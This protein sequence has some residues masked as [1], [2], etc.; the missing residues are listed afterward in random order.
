MRLPEIRAAQAELAAAYGIHGFCY[1][2]YWFNGHRVLE[3]P[4]ND[5]CK[6][7]E[8]DFPLFCLCWANENWMRRWD[9]MDAEILLAQHYTPEDDLAHIR[10]LI[11]YFSDPRYI[12]V[13]DRPFFAVY[14]A[15]KL[16]DPRRTTDIWRQEAER[17][18]LKGLYLVR[19]ESHVE[20]GDPRELGF[21]CA[22]DFQP[23]SMPL[24]R[25]QLFRRKWWHRHKLGTG[26][27]GLAQNWVFEYAA[28]LRDLDNPLPPY[29]RI[30]CVSPGWD[31]SPSTKS[32]R[33]SSSIPRPISTS[34]GCARSP[35][36]KPPASPAQATARRAFFP[37]RS[38]SSMAGTIGL[39]AI[40]WR[41]DENWGHAY[42]NARKKRFARRACTY[43]RNAKL[44]ARR[45][46][47]ERL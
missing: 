33:R 9:G 20:S 10:A 41:V 5:I 3:R 27:P 34:A 32:A 21:D 17:A 42:L 12:R 39:K 31:N 19:V 14:R 16:P 15:T 4:V 11:P 26:E 13:N 24:Y 44:P 45:R 43:P 6:T 23:R 47:D 40:I 7:G 2:H 46:C 37:N 30:P 22:L 28:L 18:G 8:P 29:P 1:Y 25:L 38:S 35:S 36:A